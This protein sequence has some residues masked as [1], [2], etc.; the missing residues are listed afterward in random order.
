MGERGERATASRQRLL[1]QGEH[2]VSVSKPSQRD[3]QSSAQDDEQN[4]L[5]FVSLAATALL[6]HV[7]PPRGLLC[8]CEPALTT[9]LSLLL[10]RSL[11]LSVL[12]TALPALLVLISRSVPRLPDGSAPHAR[13]SRRLQ[14]CFSSCTP[15]GGTAYAVPRWFR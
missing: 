15:K 6:A 1:G 2:S 7:S 5:A 10:L 3:G 9:L 11:P 13:T 14:K 8:A 12:P 4:K